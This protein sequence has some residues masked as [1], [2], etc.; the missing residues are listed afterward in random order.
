MLCFFFLMRGGGKQN[1]TEIIRVIE[2]KNSY[3]FIDLQLYGPL[4]PV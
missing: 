2:K 1:F 4:K 3:T